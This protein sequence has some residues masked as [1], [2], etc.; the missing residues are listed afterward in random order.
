MKNILKQIVAIGS[1]T[2]RELVREKILWSTVVFSF[3]VMALS[4]AVA[5]ISI[6]ESERITLDFG[7]AA[8]GMI[9]SLMAVVVGGSLISREVKDRTLY[10]VLTKSIWRWQFVLG[11][12]F[13]FYGII[14]L[15]TL[16]MYLV[17]AGI[18]IFSGGALKIQYFYNIHMQLL[19]FMVLA[20]IGVF[21]SCFTTSVLSTIF[22]AGLWIIGHAMDDVRLAVEKIALDFVKDI[23]T[24]IIKIIPDLT[25]FD[26]KPQLSHGIP[27]EFTHILLATGYGFVFIAFTLSAACFIFSKRDL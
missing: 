2:F 4:Y 11:K 23:A 7:A 13:G 6:Y 3:L 21:F 9:G 17:L 16:V 26:V 8:V 20:S 24:I 15:N 25:V 12:T 5:Q 10:L 19:E 22:S 1:V 18:Y 27:V 14:I